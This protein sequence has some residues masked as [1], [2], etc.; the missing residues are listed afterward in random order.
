VAEDFQKTFDLTEDDVLATELFGPS[1]GRE[2]RNNAIKAIL[3]AAV[4]ML[5]Y[6]RLRFRK[7]KFGAAA[8]AGVVH[9]VLW[10][11]AFYAIFQVTV[12]NPFI[13]AILTVVGYSIN[14]TIVV[15][16]RIRENNRFMRKESEEEIID[17]SIN[18]T[19]TRSVMTSMTTLIVLIPL[20]ILTTSSIREF[21][22]PLMVGIIVGMLSSIFVCSPLYYEFSKLGSKK[23]YKSAASK[24]GRKKKYEK[25]ESTKKRPERKQVEEVPEKAAMPEKEPEEVEYIVE[26]E[27]E[28]VPEEQARERQINKGK[29][30]KIRSG[31]NKKGK[32]KKR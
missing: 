30:N 1:V 13:A 10:V 31:K 9:D 21:V 7:W 27:E 4:G 23:H 19:L 25:T 22:L 6:I 11:L 2:L 8:L 5:I 15:F 32:K 16:D 17:T 24:G 14:D 20:Y 29:K 12:N 26:I 18:Q 3:L 28:I